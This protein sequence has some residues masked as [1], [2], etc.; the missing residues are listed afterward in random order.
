MTT[1]LIEQTARGVVDALSHGEPRCVDGDGQFTLHPD[2]LRGLLVGFAERILHETPERGALTAIAQSI[3]TPVDTTASDLDQIAEELYDDYL[4]VVNV[5]R[6]ALG[7]PPLA[8][9]RYD[10]D[11]DDWDDETNEEEDDDN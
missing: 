9:E 1:E 4:T 2:R 7:Q 3:P 8:A 10:A 6:K 11:A 5:A